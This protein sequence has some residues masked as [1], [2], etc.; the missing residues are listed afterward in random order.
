MTELSK[1]DL[2]IREISEVMEILELNSCVTEEMEDTSKV[3]SLITG[4]SKIE[5]CEC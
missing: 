1:I 5:L 2:E 3:T 4:V